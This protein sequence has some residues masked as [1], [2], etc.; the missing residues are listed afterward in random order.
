[1]KHLKTIG[2]IMLGAITFGSTRAQPVKSLYDFKIET[3]DG[4]TLSLNTLRG[5]KV[6][7]VNTASRCGYTKQYANLQSLY[8]QYKMHDFEI[9]GFPANNFKNQEPGSNE[10]IA[11]F[12][13]KNYGVTFL[14]SAKIDVV[15]EAQYPL[16]R[17]LTTKS[18]NG[19]MDSEVKWNFQKYLVDETGKL[20][21]VAYSK[22]TPDSDRIVEWIKSGALKEN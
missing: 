14:M 16:Y 21:G 18:E 9:V 15:G 13:A 5:K 22:E 1:M 3:L 8:E 17:W 7:I 12:C 11:A 10:E 4:K 19:V 2:L 6:M 20:V